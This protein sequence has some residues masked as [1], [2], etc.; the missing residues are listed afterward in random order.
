MAK[1]NGV[2]LAKAYVQIIPSMEGVQQGI[3]NALNGGSGG[4]S[5]IGERAGEALGSALSSAFNK[6][7]AFIGDSIETGMGFDSAM[8]QVAATMGKTVDEIAELRD[9]AKEMGAQTA[10]SATQSAEALNYMALAGYDAETSMKMLPNVMDLAASGGMELARASDMVTDSQT[11]LGL[12]IEETEKLVDQMAKTAST[13]NT[14]VSQLG[15]AILTIGGTAKNLSG[16]TEELNQVLGILADNGIKASEAGTHLRNILLAMSPSS[17]EAKEAFEK[18]SFSAYDSQGSLREM[19]GIFEELSKKMKDMGTEERTNIIKQMFKE[20]DIAA[21]NALLDT[22]ADRWDTVAGAIENADG[23][24]KAMSETQLDNLEGDITLLKSAFEGLQI[25]VSDQLTP[26]LRNLV[27]VA[28]EGLTWLT[29]HANTLIG[30]I[31][32]IGVAFAAI[33]LPAM[34][35]AAKTAMMAFNAVCAQNGLLVLLTAAVTVGLTLKGV[36]DDCT[37][38][39]NEIPDAYEGL[40]EGEV[41]FVKKIADGTDNLKEAKERLAEAEDKLS[42][43]QGRRDAAQSARDAAQEEYN[44]ILSK[45]MITEEEYIRQLELHDSILPELNAKLNDERQAVGALATAKME[46]QAQVNALTEAEEQ[47]QQQL[48]ETAEAESQAAEE[49]EKLAMSEE[50]YAEAVKTAMKDALALT[51]D[52]NGEIAELDRD[53]AEKMGNIIDE[54]DKM[55]ESQRKAIEGTFDLFNGF[56]TDTSVTFGELMKN[57]KDTNFYMNDWATAIE[58]LG[59]KGVSKKLLEELK[60]M[61]AD[62]WKYVYALNHASKEQLKQYSDLWDRTSDQV[63]ETTER[64]LKGQ[65]EEF[66]TEL[67]NISGIPDAKIEDFRAA[68]ER[69]GF[70]G[71]DSFAKAIEQH[72]DKADDAVDKLVEEVQKQVKAND[73][74][75]EESG[76]FIVKGLDEGMTGDEGMKQLDKATVEMSDEIKGK[77]CKIMEI[78]SPS[79]VF[80][81]YGKNIDL[82]LAGGIK[83]NADE[84]VNAVRYMVETVISAAE[85]ALSAADLSL[86]LGV[87]AAALDR[88]ANVSA[89]YSVKASD[90]SESAKTP[91]PATFQLVA[92]SRVVAEWLFPDMNDLFGKTTTLQLKGVAT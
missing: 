38:A 78:N 62:G 82:G 5:G 12:S 31:E 80:E 30:V 91:S 77:F 75:L 29:D 51:I 8:S 24:A 83:D 44:N 27:Q 34:I 64:M 85:D 65:R 68:F 6:A 72:F 43:A 86:D 60:G 14:S 76:L 18:L 15:D 32:A 49:A 10:F 50:Q 92:G 26:D 61:G 89:S 79:G 41:D 45:S 63:G 2:E 54:Y 70:E 21:V 56:K 57:L 40:D 88:A 73:Q 22:T 4:M 46:A 1:K 33:K 42:E 74:T 20:T 37:A 28:T 67:A 39:I 23:A 66:E 52:V 13:T 48:E 59:E 9:Y 90:K 53:N 11:A 69:A 36:I 19:S 55:Y 58:Q 47:A 25:E 87:N 16:G 3:E 71:V 7:A 35:G 84:A 81:D 17:K